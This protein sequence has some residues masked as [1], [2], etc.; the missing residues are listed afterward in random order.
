MTESGDTNNE[1]YVKIRD[2][3]I[4]YNKNKLDKLTNESVK[5]NSQ[6]KVLLRK[7]I[8]F[9]YIPKNISIHNKI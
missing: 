7:S 3:F 6:D 8:A 1:I 2:D 9:N 5:Q 4:K